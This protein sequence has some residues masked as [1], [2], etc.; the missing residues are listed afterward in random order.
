MGSLQQSW[1]ELEFQRPLNRIIWACRLVPWD[2]RIR[3]GIHYSLFFPF[4][5][6]LIELELP[7]LMEIGKF[8][9]RPRSLLLSII[10]KPQELELK[11][12]A[13]KRH[14]L[15]QQHR[16][17]WVL[18]LEAHCLF[19]YEKQQLIQV[20]RWTSRYSSFVLPCTLTQYRVI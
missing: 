16:G 5:R 7:N 2:Q 19:Y 20:A 11:L 14:I 18:M 4:I 17:F 15:S 6:L 3:K 13:I 9:P 1:I 8:D 10:S 12:K